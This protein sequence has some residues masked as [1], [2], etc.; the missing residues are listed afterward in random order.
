MENYN[1][2]IV[3]ATILNKIDDI[4]NE[5]KNSH[6]KSFNE[7]I[8]IV[9]SSP[10]LQL[11]F[12]VI[13]NI[14][15]KFIDNEIMALKYIDDNIKLFEIYTIDEIDGEREKL[16]KFIKES[17]IPENDRIKLYGAIDVLINESLSDYNDIDVNNVYEATASILNHLKKEKTINE[18]IIQY[19]PI[20]E[21]V[22]EIAVNKFNEK[23][24]SLDKF[25]M[26]LLKSLIYGDTE[27]RSQL[28]ETYKRDLLHILNEMKTE[29][30]QDNI[31]KSIKKIN[32]MKYDKKTV[33]DDIIKLHEFK[34][35]IIS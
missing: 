32:E 28:L 20:N 27:K 14:E 26:D 23:Y 2:G 22:V 7:I 8:N 11:E 5:S 18:N 17:E 35:D 4:L 1:I 34:K 29:N 10:I 6:I 12:K 9:K 33:I 31:E 24:S 3:N 15:N 21:E 13:D 16:N 25:D 30:V 19:E